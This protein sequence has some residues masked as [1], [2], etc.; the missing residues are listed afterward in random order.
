[1][2]VAPVVVMPDMASKKASVK[3]SFNSE[4]ANGNDAKR[5]RLNQLK[6]INKKASRVEIL[7]MVELLLRMRE[8][9]K[10]E[11]I[12][13]QI[14]NIFQSSLPKYR[15]A[16]IGITMLT[17]MMETSIPTMKRTDLKFKAYIQCFRTR[18]NQ[19][20]VIYPEGACICRSIAGGWLK[21]GGENIPIKKAGVNPGFLKS[22]SR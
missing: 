22:V 11:V 6:K 4:N 13:I 14:K 3:L 15:S 1:M 7:M 19:G 17:A 5:A 20:A 21:E 8:P 10:N 12:T 2:T 9:P 18:L 16:I